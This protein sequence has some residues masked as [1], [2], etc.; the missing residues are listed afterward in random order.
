MVGMRSL[1]AVRD[2]SLGCAWFSRRCHLK[3]VCVRGA[4][5]GTVVVFLSCDRVLVPQDRLSVI[6]PVQLSLVLVYE[7]MI[8]AGVFCEWEVG[9]V[10]WRM[11]WDSYWDYVRRFVL[12][13]P[14]LF[15]RL[16]LGVTIGCFC[17]GPW[18]RSCDVVS[19]CLQCSQLYG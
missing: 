8:V 4:L 11:L 1:C 2:S 3:A 14:S 16:L 15:L 13:L 6:G 18:V 10:G 12:C 19:S 5:G 17:M 7:G 9:G